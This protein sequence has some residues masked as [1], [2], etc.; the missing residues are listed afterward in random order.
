MTR[1]F[2]T[3]IAWCALNTFAFAN[4]SLI[5]KVSRIDGLPAR[6]LKAGGIDRTLLS[7]GKSIDLAPALKAMGCIIEDGET[8][9]YHAPSGTLL[10]NLSERNNGIVDEIIENLCRTDNLLATFRVYIDL[11]EPLSGVERLK[12]VRRIGFLPDALV[13]SLVAE[14]SSVEGDKAKQELD[15]KTLAVLNIALDRMKQ[16]LAVIQIPRTE[17]SASPNGP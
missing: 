14:T 13:S 2:L 3:I 15:R 1:Y 5:T 10:R 7:D 4:S 8:I 9:I 12:V 6:I 17:Q 11:L 16:Q